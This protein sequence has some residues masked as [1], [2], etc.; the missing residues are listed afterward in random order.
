MT[1]YILTSP[2]FTGE[3]IFGYNEI[4]RLVLYENSSGMNEK[5]LDWVLGNLPQS[6]QWIAT[7]A[8]K[9]QGVIKEVPQDLS[10]DVFW[11]K[12]S[13]KINKKRTKPLYD[14]LKDADKML[15]IIRVPEYLDACYR[16]KRGIVDP[17]NYIR[18]AYYETDWKQEK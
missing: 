7:I 6:K 16:L 1:K 2:K 8:S 9:I 5:Q 4:D 14:R 11:A 18:G 17:E 10:F 12:Y 3:V 13:K 15:A